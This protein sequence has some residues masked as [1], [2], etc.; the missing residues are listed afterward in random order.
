MTQ[1]N[2][3]TVFCFFLW[4]A[5]AT[6]ALAQNPFLAEALKLD[7]QG[8]VEES[9]SPWKQFIETGPEKDL[10]IYAQIKMCIALARFSRYTEAVEAAKALARKYPDHYDVQFNLGNMLSA[11]H[12]F[13]EAAQA[14]QSTVQLQKNEGL[15]YVGL[16]LSLFGTQKVDQSVKTL[17]MVRKLF[18]AQKNIPW[19]QNVRIMIGQIKGF[20]PYP[21]DFS[22]LWLANNL[23]LVHSTYEK[24]VFKNFEDNLNF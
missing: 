10:H 20:A 14:Y 17:R 8:F 2:R 23:K 21:P 3:I 5:L 12:Q 7:R 19:Y 4:V 24:S 6:P 15:G 18:K 9:I 16:G 22:N 11:T 13:E 1:H